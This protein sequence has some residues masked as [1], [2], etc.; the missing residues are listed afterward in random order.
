MANVGVHEHVTHQLMRSK[1]RGK[2]IMHSQDS[3]QVDSLLFESEFCKKQQ[4][5]DDQDVFYGGSQLHHG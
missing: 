4:N 5:T 2:G 3:I 1:Q